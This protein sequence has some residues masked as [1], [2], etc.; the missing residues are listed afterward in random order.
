MTAINSWRIVRQ[1]LPYARRHA[2][3]CACAVLTTSDAGGNEHNF[4]VDEENARKMPNG[5]GE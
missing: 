3:A 2:R 4:G 5:I 1:K